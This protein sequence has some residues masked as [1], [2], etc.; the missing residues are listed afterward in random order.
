M[1]PR[2]FRSGSLYELF[3]RRSRRMCLEHRGSDGVP[4]DLVTGGSGFIGRHVVAALRA[5]GARVRVLDL[6]PPDDP[7]PDVEFVAGLDPRSGVPRRGDGGRPARVSS[8]RHRQALVARPVRFRP[9]QCRRHR[10]GHAR[11]RRAPRRARRALLDRS[12]PAAE[13]PRRRRAH[14]RDRAAGAFR[15]ARPLY[16]LEARGRAGRARRR[17]GRAR[18]ADRQSDRADRPGR[19]QSARRR[20]PCCRCS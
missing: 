13:A 7:A 12:D 4:I 19:P 11:G 17:A 1:S 5:R 20:R 9:R 2:C 6:A 16:A 15:H 14:R 3:S 8:R 18:C 10:D